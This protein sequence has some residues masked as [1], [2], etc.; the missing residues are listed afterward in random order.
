M[1]RTPL[2]MEICRVWT[3]ATMNCSEMSPV[4]LL[5]FDKSEICVQIFC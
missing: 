4:F 3:P 1:A 5:G 2:Q